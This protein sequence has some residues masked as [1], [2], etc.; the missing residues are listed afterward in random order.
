MFSEGM[1]LAGS[2]ILQKGDNPNAAIPQNG[3]QDN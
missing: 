1:S 3:G 2:L